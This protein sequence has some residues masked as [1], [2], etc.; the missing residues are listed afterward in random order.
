MLKRK[1]D[2]EPGM[3]LVNVLFGR[4]S[5]VA[6]RI[7]EGASSYYGLN[8]KRQTSKLQR[9]LSTEISF[10]IGYWSFFG[11]WTFAIWDF[12]RIG[13]PIAVRKSAASDV[14][15]TCAGDRFHPSASPF[16]RFGCHNHASRW[17]PR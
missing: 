4:A 13:Y 16:R 7:F 3:G 8:P 9:S 6:R 11:V 12:Q 10:V 17:C 14:E 5:D 15:A 1:E 2:G